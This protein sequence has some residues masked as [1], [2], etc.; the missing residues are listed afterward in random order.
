MLGNKPNCLLDRVTV[1]FKVLEGARLSLFFAILWGNLDV[2]SRWISDENSEFQIYWYL[3]PYMTWN[4][5]PFRSL[6]SK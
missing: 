2:R 3:H 1:P 5:A 4:S 6:R